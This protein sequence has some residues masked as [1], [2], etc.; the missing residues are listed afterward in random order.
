MFPLLSVCACSNT[1]REQVKEDNPGIKFGEVAKK[2]SE[3]W[4]SVTPSEKSKF[5][6]VSHTR[7][8][9]HTA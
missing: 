2:I 4:K 8:M 6:K 1:K 9:G 3:L 7:Y 5:E